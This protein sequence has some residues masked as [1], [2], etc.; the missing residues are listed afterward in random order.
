M[1]TA[2]GKTVGRYRVLETI[3]SSGIAT[4]YK[5][6]DP[7]LNREVALKVLHA[8][9]AT[10]RELVQRFMGEMDAVVHLR[11]PNIVSV[12]EYGEEDGNV[13]IAMEY[14]PGGSLKGLLKG[15]LDFGI[16]V[17]IVSGVAAALDYAHD[18]G[19]THRNIKLSNIFVTS[20]GRVLLSDFGMATL[21][22]GVHP[23]MKTGLTTP[24]PEYMSPEQTGGGEVDKRSD[25]YALGVL[26]YHLLT[27][28]VPYFGYSPDTV[29][30]KQTIY[31]PTMPSTLNPAIPE[32]ADDVI[33]KALAIKPESR[34]ATA[35]EMAQKLEMLAEAEEKRLSFEDAL[36]EAAR[37]TAAWPETPPPGW[38]V[39]PECGSINRPYRQF[40]THCGARLPVVIS[41]VEVLSWIQ[42]FARWSPR[43]K[44]L[45][46]LVS[47][48]A[49]SLLASGV[50]Y[51]ASRPADLLPPPSSSISSY[52]AGEWAMWGRD[53]A[54]TSYEEVVDSQP[55]GKLKWRFVTSAPIRSSVAVVGGTVYLATGE[56]RIVALDADS[57][58]FLWEAKVTGPVDSSPAVANGLVYVGLYDGRLLA[59]DAQSGELR[60]EFRTNN[61]IYGSPTVADG[62]VYVGSGDNSVYA[63]DALTGSLRWSYETEGWIA[64]SPAVSRGL[65]CV[66]SRGWGFYVL[67]AETGKELLE[68]RL[69]A[70]IDSSPAISGNIAYVGSDAREMCAIDLRARTTGIRARLIERSRWFWNH[71][72]TWGIAPEPPPTPGWVWGAR[73]RGPVTAAPAVDGDTVYFGSHD[74]RLYALDKATGKQRWQFVTG[75][76]VS[77]SPV[78]VGGTIYFGSDDNR[79]YALDGE[80]GTKLWEFA[81]GGRIKASPAVVKG[82]IYIGSTDGVL[83]AIE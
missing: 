21:G 59:L 54:R 35:G 74:A 52:S 41:R 43:R 73:A 3:G 44:A 6:Y 11:H 15:P 8:Y 53:P 27:Q 17:K 58:K 36:K 48:L 31:L 30:A 79:L 2:V 22:E 71:L 82:V 62:V 47:I 55:Q 39:C 64:S 63:V 68:T 34:Y 19:I 24:M 60:W 70:P 9:F 56:R 12:Y 10:E 4:V 78:V 51:A 38:I 42:R 72:Y 76:A 50:A 25:I 81:T 75:G 29:W 77:S 66:T 1:S 18:R 45:A 49:V 61:P 28:Q 65:V 69:L 80:S 23:L 40:C 37:G 26:I 7:S 20:E 14:I 83:Y 33:A 32:A 13:W 16:S 57:G 67:D 46:T 5:A